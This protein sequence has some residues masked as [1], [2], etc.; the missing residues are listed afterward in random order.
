MQT[1]HLNTT[2]SSRIGSAYPVIPILHKYGVV[3]TSCS[4]VSIPE[5]DAPTRNF[6]E[7]DASMP[8]LPI[9]VL[10]KSCMRL[11]LIQIVPQTQLATRCLK[12]TAVVGLLSAVL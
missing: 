9:K 3:R 4:L 11:R 10:R 1:D 5:Q 6:Q 2:A 8:T 12:I 7:W